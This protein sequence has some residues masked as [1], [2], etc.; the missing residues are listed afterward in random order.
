MDCKASDSL[1]SFSARI[2]LWQ[3]SNI[4]SVGSIRLKFDGCLFV[5]K[6]LHSAY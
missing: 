4:N 6:A 2:A 3:T 5:V 1:V